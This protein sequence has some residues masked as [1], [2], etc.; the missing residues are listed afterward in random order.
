L[1]YPNLWGNRT[2]R[3]SALKKTKNYRIGI[4]GTNATIKSRTY[5]AAIMARV[6]KAKV[7]AKACPLLVPLV[8]EG[9]INNKVT[10]EVLSIY[11]KPLFHK[12]IDVLVL[13]CTH[14]PLLKSE[15]KKI[16]GTKIALVDSAQSCA[17]SV[18]VKLENL[19]LL[20]SSSDREGNVTVYVTDA[21]EHFTRLADRFLGSALKS[22]WKAEL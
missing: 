3:S 21:P 4:I 11:L 13:G 6:K 10:K 18:K 16:T 5:V 22:A 19:D 15:I 8:E 1:R 12:N 9:W 14:Y 2:G 7:F 20:H 17:E